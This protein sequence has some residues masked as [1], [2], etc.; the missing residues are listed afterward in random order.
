MRLSAAGLV[1]ACMLFLGAGTALGEVITSVDFT[2]GPAGV[3]TDYSPAFV[4][5]A[6]GQVMVLDTPSAWNSTYAD[7]V[8]TGNM[9]VA[10]GATSHMRVWYQDV[11][12]TAGMVYQMSFD[13][14]SLTAEDSQFADLGLY[15]RTNPYASI[16]VAT[17]A[18]DS[19][20]GEWKTAFG[21]FTPTASGSVQLFIGNLN[22]SATGNAFAVDNILV[23]VPEPSSLALLGAGSLFGLG[24]Y[25]R[26]RRQIA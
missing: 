5:N 22:T 11:V 6:P 7:P 23:H 20:V 12:L 1:F 18:L 21:S 25:T 17:I 3:L 13:A 19:S 4:N 2:S 8:G 10:D 16:P 15:V 9:L 24:V 26:R 14:A